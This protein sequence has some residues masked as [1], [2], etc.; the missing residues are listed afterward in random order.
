MA[1][2]K[3]DTRA[4]GVSYCF[5]S[6]PPPLSS[7]SS[8]ASAPPSCA[9]ASSS[10]AAR[11]TG[12]TTSGPCVVARPPLLPPCV[13]ARPLLLPGLL[14]GRRGGALSA[15]RVR[16]GGECGLAAVPNVPG[17]RLRLTRSFHHRFATHVARSSQLAI[18]Y[19]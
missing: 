3:A 1:A 19:N 14:G 7:S 2:S 5:L 17:L 4:V 16:S 13:V 10:S 9:A 6:P 15:R 8:S 18:K 11:D 12:G